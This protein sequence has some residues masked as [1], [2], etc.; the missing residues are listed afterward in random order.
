MT[1]AELKEI[2]EQEMHHPDILGR[3]AYPLR[4]DKLVEQRHHDGRDLDVIW[5]NAGDSWRCTIFLDR[6]TDLCLVQVDLRTDSTV[7]VEAYEPCSVTI[8]PQ[9]DLL[10]LTRYRRTD[11]PLQ[12]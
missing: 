2:V 4:N 1:P 8:S 12:P 3:L 11:M 5:R 10:C 9:D 6:A 7:R